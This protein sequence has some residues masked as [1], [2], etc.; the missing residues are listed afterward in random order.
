LIEYFDCEVRLRKGRKWL[1]GE[2]IFIDK[3]GLLFRRF[4]RFSGE[5]DCLLV[6]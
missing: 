5:E 4:K 1:E 3:E 2:G 6:T